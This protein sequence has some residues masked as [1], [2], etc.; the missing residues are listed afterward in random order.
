MNQ[1]LMKIT[2]SA[3]LFT[4]VFFTPVYLRAQKSASTKG[5]SQVRMESNM[6]KEQARD[7]AEDLA[8]IN[9]VEN[10]FGT[11][12]EQDADIKVDNGIVSYN[13]IG[14]T[15]VKG[16]WL[17]TTKK[18]FSEDIQDQLDNDKNKEKVIWIT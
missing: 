10:A 3:I 9:A 5:T 11:Y 13:I 12:V 6:T 2:L 15:R 16:E 17:R 14:T 8:M 18:V 4:W 1:I 7:K